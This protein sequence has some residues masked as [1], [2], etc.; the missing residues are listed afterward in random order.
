[1]YCAVLSDSLGGFYMKYFLNVLNGAVI[2]LIA[3]AIW[4]LLPD[5]LALARKIPAFFATLSMLSMS[6]AML[7]S[8]RPKWIDYLLGGIDKAYV[9]HK[10]L[11]ILGLLGASFHW[12]LVPGPAG[13]GMNPSFAEFGEEVGQWAVYGLLLLG[14]TSM[15]KKIPYRLWYYLHQLMGPI[16]IIA[17]YHTFFSDAPF[18]IFSK[19]GL[20]LVLIALLGISSWLYK[21]F[22]KPHSYLK[23]RVEGINRLDDAIELVLA[24][25]NEKLHYH[26]GQFAYLDFKLSKVAHFHPFT[27]TSTRDDQTLSFIIRS[28]GEHTAVLQNNVKVGAEVIVDGGYGRMFTKMRQQ[29]PQ[30]WIAGGI[31]ITP[32]LSAI[33]ALLDNNVETHL[34]FTAKGEFRDLIITKISTLIGAK[35]VHF[36]C[37]FT[38]EKRLNA[39]TICS[40]LGLPLNHYKVFACGPAP[41][42]S[43]LNSQLLAKGMLK[44]QWHSEIF[45]MR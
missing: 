34:F 30:I 10:W 11:G 21:I 5:E 22:I 35:R 20:A 1:V 17:V 40:V 6:V 12:L 7:L 31:G 36:H 26:T 4:L 2:T 28:L 13:S 41:L 14:M 15:I 8:C 25:D 3:V 24:P 39:D 18:A 37:D 45:T 16:F 27:I 19:T 33:R 23:Y 29:S 43:A 32:Y 9:W 38:Q 44:K 42:L